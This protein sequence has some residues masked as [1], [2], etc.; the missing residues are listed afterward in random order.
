MGPR[1]VLF[2]FAH[3]DDESFSGAGTAMT[4]A[5]AGARIVLMTATLGE[6]GKTGDP[7]VCAPGDLAAW[8][9]RELRM[10]RRWPAKDVFESLSYSPSP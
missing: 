5:A 4:C 9:G 8:R 3:P 1:C 6:R 7:P 10:P 2:V